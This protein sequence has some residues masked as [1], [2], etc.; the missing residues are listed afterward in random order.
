MLVIF[1]FFLV[2]R[3]NQLNLQVCRWQVCPITYTKTNTKKIKKIKKQKQ[4]I[5]LWYHVYSKCI[6]SYQLPLQ[7]DFF[8]E[9]S[10]N[11]QN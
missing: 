11:Y 9:K 7:N 1:S 8:S 5:Y 6:G 4:N 3:T 2:I 10:K